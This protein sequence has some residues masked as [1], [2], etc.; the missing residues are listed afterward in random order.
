[1]SIVTFLFSAVWYSQCVL[2][3]RTP[4]PFTGSDGAGHAPEAGGDGAGHGSSDMDYACN[5]EWVVLGGVTY[6]V[7]PNIADLFRSWGIPMGELNSVS[8]VQF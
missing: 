3:L 7:P 5:R 4:F 6:C 8:F 1:M 2:I